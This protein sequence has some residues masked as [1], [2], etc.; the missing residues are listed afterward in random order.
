[1]TEADD[2]VM[3]REGPGSGGGHGFDDA[4]E[5]D[6]V[7]HALGHDG[8]AA[9]AAGGACHAAGMRSTRA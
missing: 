7:V 5:H 9:D 2:V 4:G 8:G 1:M 3:Q 6:D